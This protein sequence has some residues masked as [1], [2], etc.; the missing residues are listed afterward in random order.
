VTA[1]A[2]PAHAA[3]MEVTGKPCG[4]RSLGNAAGDYTGVL[5]A[6]PQKLSHVAGSPAVSGS[7]RCTLQLDGARHADPD[8]AVTEGPVTPGVAVAPPVPVTFH[9][10]PDDLSA[11]P[12]VCAQVDIPGEGTYYWAEY[13]DSGSWSTDPASV[14]EDTILVHVVPPYQERVVGFVIT[15]LASV[16][17]TIARLCDVDACI[18]P[19]S[20][21]T[22]ADP[23]VC[24]VL[25]SSAPGSGP[26]TIAPD[27]DTYVDSTLLWD[28]PPYQ[29][30]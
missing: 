16:D 24:P 25:A 27:G 17:E 10:D 30:G 26:L 15:A 5:Y 29:D 2:V 12:A 19:W 20:S 8:T 9:L 14:C 4:L 3:P 21:L 22:Q 11:F 1:F 7:L 18:P 13:G 23:L 28:C 6:T